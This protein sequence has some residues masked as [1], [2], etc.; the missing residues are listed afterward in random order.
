MPSEL[1]SHIF[2]QLHFFRHW[3]RPLCV[4]LK[5]RRVKL[6]SLNIHFQAFFMWSIWVDRN[7]FHSGFVMGGVEWNAQHINTYLG[8]GR[9]RHKADRMQFGLCE[10]KLSCFGHVWLI[11]ALWTMDHQAI[12]SMQ[13]S[14]Q[15]YWGRLWHPLPWDLTNQGLKQ[16]FLC[17][18][19]WQESFFFTAAAA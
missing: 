1:T 19:N 9:R 4:S 6:S 5:S 18:L 13:F 17:L 8:G 15:E 7:S 14:T 10:C 3:N 16:H 11:A 12:L 2:S